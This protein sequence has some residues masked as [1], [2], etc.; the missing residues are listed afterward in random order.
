MNEEQ[1]MT[2]PAFWIFFPVAAVSWT[3][4]LGRWILRRTGVSKRLAVRRWLRQDRSRRM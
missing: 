2:N 4:V 1:A 3:A